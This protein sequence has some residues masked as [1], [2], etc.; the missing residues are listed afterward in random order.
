M[1]VLVDV[2]LRSQCYDFFHTDSF[3][4]AS[5]L[6]LI[7]VGHLFLIR[8][9]HINVVTGVKP[10]PPPVNNVLSS[11]LSLSAISFLRWSRA[12]VRILSVAGIVNK[13]LDRSNILELRGISLYN[14]SFNV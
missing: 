6:F 8:K 12:F 13:I 3:S 4:Y 14:V 11:I 9:Y 1:S 5:D 10:Q 7:I 2:F